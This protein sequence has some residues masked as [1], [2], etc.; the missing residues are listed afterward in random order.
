MTLE[1]AQ[2]QLAELTKQRDADQAEIKKLNE[3]ISRQNS[4]ITKLEAKANS[5]D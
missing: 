5:N 4:Y 2:A 3:N 1:E